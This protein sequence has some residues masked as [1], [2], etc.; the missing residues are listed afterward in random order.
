MFVCYD[1]YNAEFC[2]YDYDGYWLASFYYEFDAY[3]YRDYMSCE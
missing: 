1:E 2:V 3:N